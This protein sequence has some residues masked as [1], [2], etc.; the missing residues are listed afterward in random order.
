VSAQAS[1][2]PRPPQLGA[3]PL[4]LRLPALAEADWPYAVGLAALLAWVAVRANGGLRVGDTT[5]VEILLDV[6]AGIVAILAILAVPGLRRRSAGTLAGVAFGLFTVAAAVSTVWSVAPDQSWIESNRLITYLAVFAT[7]FALVRLAPHRWSA[8]LGGLTLACIVVSAWA[9]A[10]KAFPSQLEPD[11]VYARLREPFGYWNAVGLMAAMGVPGCLWLGARRTGHAALNA[12]AYPATGLLLVV[13]LLAY[14]RG[15]LLALALGC[16]FWFAVTPLRLRGAAVLAAGAAGAALVIAW[17]F[18]Q[19]AL[20]KDNVDLGLRDQAGHQLAI[21]VA[22]MLV[23][24]LAAGLAVLFAVAHRPPRERLRRRAGVAILVA[25]ALVPV[26]VA[27]GLATTH[28]GLGG[29][30]AHGWRSL[31]DPNARTP[32]NAPGRLTA[33]GSVRARYWNEALK[34]FRDHPVLGVGLGGYQDARLRYRNDDLAVQHA[35]GYVVQVLADR[36]VVGLVLSLAA[37]ALLSVAIAQATGLRRGA[38]PRTSPERV[39]LLTLTALIVVFGVHS[40]VD[41]TWYVP[42]VAI[43]ALL[44]GGWLAGRGALEVRPRPLTGLRARARR[45]LDS[46]LRLQASLLAAAIAIAAAWAAWQPQRSIQA[47]DEA[48][49]AAAATPPNFPQARTLAAQARR[50]DPLSVEPDLDLAAI[51]IE[52]KRL[53][54]AQAALQRAVRLQPANPET[55]LRLADFELHQLHQPRAA[56]RTLGAALYLDPRSFD[57][58]RL[59]LQAQRALGTA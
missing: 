6:L 23:A 40:F 33:V 13:L 29:S 52:A 18:S 9:L 7:G 24:L 51:E 15:A 20:T 59:L 10:H 21:A 16:A 46:P 56:L 12:L 14:S 19:P 41:W 32:S 25:L 42:G 57:G 11:E 5:A 1:P 43:P 34:I 37:L 38:R 17:A 4:A 54:A 39:A 49:A 28:R 22:F 3:R 30:I 31:T 58:L 45:G 36:G 35:H 8:L 50:T 2:A 55:W 27:I 44:A 53:P 47:G 48:L 26:G